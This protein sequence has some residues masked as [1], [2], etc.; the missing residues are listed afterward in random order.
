MDHFCLRLGS[1]DEEQIRE[2]LE[3]F[4]VEAGATEARYG[5]RGMG[6]SIY[7]MNPDCKTL[8]PKGSAK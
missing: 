3:H 7:V 6:P 1:F 4:G 2:H 5:A 8:E